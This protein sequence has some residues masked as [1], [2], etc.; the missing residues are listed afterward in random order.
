MECAVWLSNNLE[1]V[2]LCVSNIVAFFVRS[3]LDRLSRN[4]IR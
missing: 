1:M 3:P 2:F 4:P